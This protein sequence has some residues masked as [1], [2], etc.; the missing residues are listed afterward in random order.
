MDSVNAVKEGKVD[1]AFVS[2]NLQVVKPLRMKILRK[3]HDILIGGSRFEELKGGGKD[4]EKELSL[5]ELVS[6]PWISLTAETIT[7]RFLNEYFE[8]NSLTFA[9]DMELATTDMILPAVRHNLG[10][11]FIP[12]EFA[13]AELESGQVF[14][15]KV[16]E[17]LPERNIILIYDAEY[18]QSIAA[19]EF[20]KFLKDREK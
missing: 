6:Y 16:K 17:K 19:K 2:A 10:L 3:Y 7:R 14:E 4:G 15:I 5:K 9:P 13:D 20:Q 1:L 8:K 11:G 18:P 12:A